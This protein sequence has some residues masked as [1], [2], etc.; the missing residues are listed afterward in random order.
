MA[1]P[2]PRRIRTAVPRRY[3]GFCNSQLQMGK[4]PLSSLAHRTLPVPDRR[5]GTIGDSDPRLETGEYGGAIAREFA[6]KDER[7]WSLSNPTEAALWALHAN[8]G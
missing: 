2:G 5:Q 1:T 8:Q 7:S 6:C 3:Q 4:E